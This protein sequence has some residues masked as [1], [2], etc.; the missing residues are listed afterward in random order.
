MVLG[1]LAMAAVVA[2][3]WWML[4]GVYGADVIAVFGLIPLGVAVYGGVLWA[5]RIE[6]REELA[7]LLAKFRKPKG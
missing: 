5:L 7:A 6:G 1:S 4:R 2:G 3:G